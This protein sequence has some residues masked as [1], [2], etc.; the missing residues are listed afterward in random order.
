[1]V[2]YNKRA[3]DK[4]RKKREKRELKEQEQ[5]YREADCLADGGHE[6]I[7]RP[8]YPAGGWSGPTIY[9]VGCGTIYKPKIPKRI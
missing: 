8:N 5:R 1:M 6:F 3:K 2:L 7:T 4:A 9:C